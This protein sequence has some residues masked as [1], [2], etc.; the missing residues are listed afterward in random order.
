MQNSVLWLQEISKQDVEL[1][2]GKGA[3][4]GEL[5]QHGILIPNG[6]CI[7]TRAYEACLRHNPAIA[8]QIKNEIDALDFDD[9]GGLKLHSHRIQE[10]ITKMDIPFALEGEIVRAYKKLLDLN[11][12]GTVAVRSSSNTEDI[13]GSSSAGQLDTFLGVSGKDSLLD[14]IKLCWA[15]LWNERSMVYRKD[16]LFS[17]Q[18]TSIAVVIQSM[19]E[20]EIAGVMFTREPLTGENIIYI[21]ASWGLGEAVVSGK[22]NPDIYVIDVGNGQPKELSFALGYKE[23]AIYRTDQ[24]PQSLSMEKRRSRCLPQLVAFQLAQLGKSI[25]SIYKHPQDIEWGIVG[26]RIYIFQSRPITTIL[27]GLSPIFNELV[28][29]DESLWTSSFFIERFPTPPSPL[30]W[31]LVGPLIEKFALR[32]PLRLIG[33]RKYQNIKVFR[34][35]RGFPFVN[36]QVWQMLYKFFPSAFLPTD[37]HRFFPERNVSM[38]RDV[39]QPRLADFIVS[40]AQ[41]LLSTS[42][43]SP[44]HYVKWSKFVLKYDN[45][46]EVNDRAIEV[47]EN[48][49]SSLLNITNGLNNLSSELLAIHR[50]SLTY[51]DMLMAILQRLLRWWIKSDN[52]EDICANLVSGLTNQ[53]TL[54]DAEIWS[55]SRLATQVNNW[56]FYLN[57]GSDKQKLVE[58]ASLPDYNKGM[59]LRVRYEIFLKKFGHRSISLDILH[60][61]FGDDPDQV[62]KLIRTLSDGTSDG[63]E[64]NV[65]NQRKKRELE[66][67][68]VKEELSRGWLGKTISIKWL[69]VDI[70][71]RFTHI[72]MRLREDQRFYW[73]KS[74]YRQRKAFIKIGRLIFQE[75]AN[76]VFF[77]TLSEIYGFVEN[78]VQVTELQELAKLR[79]GEFYKIQRTSCPPFLKGN[80]PYTPISKREIING[81]VVLQGIPVSPGRK[82]GHARIIAS[83]ENL[84]Q[85]S[86]L[87]EQGDILV[88]KCTDPAWTPILPK[89]GGLVMET[90]GSLSH[91]SVIAREYGI[92]AVVGITNATNNIKQGELL[93]VD[94]SNGIVTRLDA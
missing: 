51:A 61:A 78:N 83:S 67:Q 33:F 5:Y 60:P 48:S 75:D 6:F 2:G 31:T 4:L 3:S 23:L 18:T 71:I 73:Q 72:Y 86:Q 94:G 90:G 87:I 47:S 91:G 63:P 93:E 52:T 14:K 54:I 59:E 89:L 22:V 11:G 34:M 68:K 13:D 35:Y 43:W 66:T 30:G 25:E 24:A 55:L 76:D 28:D 27:A 62:I 8:E 81:H 10:I 44:W 65:E 77:L 74:L 50:W 1:A 36:V 41:Y 42:D 37:A 20:S 56:K 39:R 46:I 15:S 64:I 17:Y 69:I 7:T 82:I 16:R 40:A 21:N 92:P 70:L 85:D 58:L 19:V 12:N 49:I 84:E 26:D 79:K 88:T 80:S 32:D 53:T 57:Q 29:D 45:E 38:R 9:V